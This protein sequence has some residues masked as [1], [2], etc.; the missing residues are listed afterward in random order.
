MED[1]RDID[2]ASDVSDDEIIEE[3]E[4]NGN[5]DEIGPENREIENHQ[6]DDN[7]D[8]EEEQ[9][10]VQASAGNRGMY[11]KVNR[12]LQWKNWRCV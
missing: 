11:S 3:Q 5:R 12:K 1:D 2:S 8:A 10:L 4:D 9:E 7:T 6:I